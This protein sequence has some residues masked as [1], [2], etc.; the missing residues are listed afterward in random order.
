MAPRAFL[1]VRNGRIF[2]SLTVM[3][4][5]LMTMLYTDG[6]AL[7]R[8]RCDRDLSARQVDVDRDDRVGTDVAAL[9]LRPVTVG[10][11]RRHQ[12]A[13]ALLGGRLAVKC[14]GADPLA[15]GEA[16]EDLGGHLLNGRLRLGW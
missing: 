6:R 4:G 8:A 9:D 2:V 11:E 10:V 13:C 3:G 16:D 14:A 5:S 1:T 15:A 12:L 7:A